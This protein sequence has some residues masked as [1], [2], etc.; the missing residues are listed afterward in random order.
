[1]ITLWI[2]KT[3]HSQVSLGHTE[4][5]LQVLQVGLSVHFSHVDK[6]WT[7]EIQQKRQ[8]LEKKEGLFKLL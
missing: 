7:G 8:K 5:L 2:Q 1:M 3:G 4:S 6:S